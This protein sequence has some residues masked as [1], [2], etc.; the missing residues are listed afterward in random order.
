M[1]NNTKLFAFRLADR[2]KADS[3]SPL[4]RARNAP[5]V[6]GCSPVAHM[7]YREGDTGMFC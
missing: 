1:Q 5:A 2:S 7:Q 3:K 4:W 6:A